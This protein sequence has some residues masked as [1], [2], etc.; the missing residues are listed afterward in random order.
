M[1][2]TNVQGELLYANPIVSRSGVQRSKQ[3][4]AAFVQRK[5]SD[6]AIAETAPLTQPKRREITR[7]VECGSPRNNGNDS[8]RND[9]ANSFTVKGDSMGSA[10]GGSWSSTEY[11]GRTGC[12]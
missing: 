4:S 5:K 12:H 10:S 1:S 8:S 2:R 7:C 11:S 6:N 9:K 3:I